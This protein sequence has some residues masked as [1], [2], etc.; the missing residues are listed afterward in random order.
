[1]LPKSFQKYLYQCVDFKH[2]YKNLIAGHRKF[3]LVAG[4][5]AHCRDKVSNEDSREG[6]RVITFD[7]LERV[8]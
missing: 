1:M 5:T 3:S 6:W 4:K 8:E 2:E 7:I